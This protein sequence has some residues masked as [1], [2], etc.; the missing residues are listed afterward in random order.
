MNLANV[1]RVNRGERRK[2]KGWGNLDRL[3][4]EGMFMSGQDLT[5]KDGPKVQ[6]LKGPFQRVGFVW[7]VLMRTGLQSP[8]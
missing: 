4:R 7:V 6:G 5:G 1:I 3:P 8:L 2:E